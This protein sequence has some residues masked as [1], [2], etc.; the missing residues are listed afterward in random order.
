MS[1]LTTWMWVGV[2]LLLLFLW[3]NPSIEF[4][5]DTTSIKGPPYSAADAD[6]IVSLM[7]STMKTALQAGGATTSAAMINGPITVIFTHFWEQKYQPATAPL[8]AAIVD[9]FLTVEPI[10]PSLTL[11]DVKSLLV[12]YFVRQA[13]GDANDAPNSAQ[14]SA[15]SRQ[16]ANAA[17]SAAN[18]AA[19]AAAMGMTGGYQA[20]PGW[21]VQQPTATSPTGPASSPTGP[22]SS[23][24]GPAS[25]PTG[26]AARGSGG[27]YNSLGGAGNDWNVR[28]YGFGSNS[29]SSMSV[30]GPGFGGMGESSGSGSGGFSSWS[31]S[32]SNYPTLIGPKSKP[33]SH[34]YSLPTPAQLGADSN[35]MYL[36]GSRVPTTGGLSTFVPATTKT[37]SWPSPFSADYSVFMK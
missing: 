15:A 35:S 27:S 21:T 28:G 32:G 31:S 23:P 33:T 4:F 5:K 12:A 30:G 10:P 37:N 20:P 36:A 18:A 29:S 8:T 9:T 7:P 24:T 2:A 14:T 1:R 22:A 26:S 25:S 11:A 6:H 19:Y 16:A 17:A 34:P 3:T 13:H